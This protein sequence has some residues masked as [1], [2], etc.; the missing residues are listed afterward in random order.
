MKRIIFLLITL[1]SIQLQSQIVVDNTAPY[2]TPN[3]LVNNILLGGGVTAINHTFQGEPSQIGWFNAINT[4][5]GIDSGIVMACGDIY[6]LDPIVGSSFPFLPNTVT[7]PDLLAVANSVPGLIGQTFSVSSIGDV[8]VLE[9]DFI[10]TSDSMEFRYAFGSQEYFAWENSSFNDVFGFFLSGPGIAGP[11]DNGA[12]N[13]AYIPNT[14]PQ[15]PITVSSVNSVTPINQQYF[16]DN[17]S[18]LNIIA[19]VKGFTTVLTAQALVQCGE[20]YHIKLA[21]ADG[22]DQSLNSYVW[23]EAGSFYSPPLSVVNNLGIDSTVM[24]IP[25]NATLTLTA[26]AGVGAS[27]EWFD[28]ATSSV[29]STNSFV[30]VGQGQYVVAADIS[31]CTKFSDTLTVISDPAPVID[32][33]PDLII[34]CNSDTIINPIVFG[35]TSPYSYLWNSGDTDSMLVLSDG[36]YYVTVTDLL[37][38]SGVDTVEVIYDATPVATI[39]GGGAICDDGTTTNIDFTFNGL[40]PWNLTYTN[41]SSSSTI[42]NINASNYS[43]TTSIPGE[44]NIA[45][46]DDPN[47]CAADI[48][49]ENITIIVKPL[50]TPLIDP[51]FSEIYPGDEV[52]LTAGTYSSY[53]WYNINDPNTIISENEILI[54]D[55]TLTT[56]LIVEAE[57]GCFG[58]SPNA[59]VNYIPRVDLF[60]PNTF[61]PNGDEHN[62]LLVIIGDKI[63]TFYM[64]ITNRWGEAVYTTNDINKF[65]DGKFNGEPVKEG[66]YSYQVAIIG[67]DGRPF[68]TT[69]TINVIY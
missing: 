32:L 66:V 22:S 36:L 1:F 60:I 50:P 14:N 57:N 17:Q 39:S 24:E 69:G 49:G 8:A 21:I 15:L 18:G 54:V 38:C 47:A 51:E 45:L 41:G 43:I 63:E 59:I 28:V 26:D 34:A 61:T 29:F 12:I 5:L 10:P 23:L 68:N 53:W 2:N 52:A 65:W 62:D 42:N 20:T 48:I 13:L 19:D 7:D 55:S 3:Y 44:Y 56:Y 27:Y 33:G 30:D 31:G 58:T 11:W 25:C 6:T 37:G 35:G 4:P 67:K 9:F 40:L 46:A 16:V 64:A